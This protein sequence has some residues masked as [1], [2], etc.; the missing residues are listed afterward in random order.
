M[1][2]VQ[3]NEL[4]CK[5]T[6]LSLGNWIVQQGLE[7]TDQETLLKGYSEQLVAVGVPL[8]R[9]HVAQRAFHP[10]FG[11]I[12]FDWTRA[13]GVSHEHYA[14]TDQPA[15]GWLQSPFYHMLESQRTQMRERL[16]APEYSSQF[17]LLNDLRDRGATEYFASSVLFEKDDTE[18]P[19]NPDQPPEG[20]LISWTSDGENGFSDS[21]VALLLELLP[22]LGL[23]LKSASNRQMAKDLM[24]VYL[25]RDAGARVLSGEFRR[26]SLR[27]I[28]AT[29]WYFDLSGFTHLTEL[30]SG[31]VLVDM[32][33]EYLGL[34][35]A[36]VHANGGNV[37]KFMGDGIM[38][39]FGQEDTAEAGLAA[40]RAGVELRSGL[41]KM[42][43]ARLAQDLPV[44]DFTLAIHAGEILYGNIGAENR[45]DFT[46]IGPAVNLTARLAGMHKALG[47]R[48]V[49][50]KAIFDATQSGEF[51]LVSLGRYMVRGVADPQTLFTIYEGAKNSPQHP[52]ALGIS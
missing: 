10:Q 25:G 29:I 52:E 17:P 32:L 18:V 31:P 12:G 16:D 40:L 41:E 45:L 1:I 26:G 11:G 23:A 50:S 8:V 30:T 33:N 2:E 37:L 19:T 48:V 47:Q 35:V 44:T 43:V 24:R 9:L 20:I 34:A 36:A 5:A 38:A 51:D 14:H 46:V 22:E 6:A 28:N 39:M 7:G 27:T 3:P 21:D 4:L 49:V 15:Q 42:N 13:D